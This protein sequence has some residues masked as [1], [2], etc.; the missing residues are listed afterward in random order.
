MGGPTI[1]GTPSP[2]GA[3]NELWITV[4]G[5]TPNSSILLELNNGDALSDAIYVDTDANGDG[6]TG[7]QCPNGGWD[8]IHINGGGANEEV[9]AVS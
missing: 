1:T 5:M 8:S 6:G 2:I 4:S 9:V 7:W 3:G